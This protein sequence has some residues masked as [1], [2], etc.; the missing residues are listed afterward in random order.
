MFKTFCCGF[1]RAEEKKRSYG[2]HMVEIPDDAINIPSSFI[3]NFSSL[4]ENIFLCHSLLSLIETSFRH[5]KEKLANFR[6]I[7]S[8]VHR[9]V[10]QLFP[11]KFLRM[12]QFHF[13]FPRQLPARRET[14]VLNFNDWNKVESKIKR[15]RDDVPNVSARKMKMNTEI[16]M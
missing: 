10:S 8:K 2:D 7:S 5:N 6:K 1:A 9:F 4:R 12:S 13:T 3:F 14:F 16:L 15:N 11:N